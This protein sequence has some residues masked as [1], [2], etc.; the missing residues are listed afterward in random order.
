[1][2]IVKYNEESF[3]KLFV[4]YMVTKNQ[5]F[6]PDKKELQKELVKF[7]DDPVCEI[8][9]RNIEKIDGI[10][11]KYVNLS[12]AFESAYFSGILRVFRDSNEDK[13]MIN[14]TPKQA[15]EIYM[16]YNYE[17]LVAMDKICRE[18][19]KPKEDEKIINLKNNYG[20]NYYKC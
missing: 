19:I 20:F 10:N 18:L 9:F 14:I 15:I 2:D 1:M 17:Q 11:Y 5:L 8:L 4:S 16:Q 12:N 3:L 7:Y 6:I 13:N